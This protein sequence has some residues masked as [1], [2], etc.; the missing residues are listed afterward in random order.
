[1]VEC[2]VYY[3]KGYFP[4]RYGT[5]ESFLVKDVQDAQ[6]LI[7]RMNKNI[8]KYCKVFNEDKTSFTL[9]NQN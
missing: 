7:N 3:N 4:S 1:M 2:I 6:L 9:I 5:Q 8:V